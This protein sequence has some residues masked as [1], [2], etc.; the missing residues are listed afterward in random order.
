[1]PQTGNPISDAE[2]LAVAGVFLL[3]ILLCFIVGYS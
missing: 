1:M 2:K 3:F